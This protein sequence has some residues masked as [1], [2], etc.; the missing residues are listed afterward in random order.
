[1][2]KFNW[3]IIMVLVALIT[4]N[5][6]P[7]H[8]NAS[9]LEGEVFEIDG[10]N[11]VVEELTQEEFIVS[12]TEDGIDYTL[13][14]NQETNEFDIKVTDYTYKNDYF[15]IG[16]Q[17]DTYN[18]EVEELTLDGLVIAEAQNIKDLNDTIEVEEQVEEVIY[19]EDE[20]ETNLLEEGNT[21]ED[22]FDVEAQSLL[23]LGAGAIISKLLISLA[24]TVVVVVVGGITYNAARTSAA[25]NK[26]K[27]A[28][29]YYAILSTKDDVFIGNKIS[30][31]SKA[32][33][34][35]KLGGGVFA[36]SQTK[37]LNAVKSASPVNKSTSVQKHT[38]GGKSYSHYHPLDAKS[39]QMRAHC[40]FY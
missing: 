27:K 34:H 31:Q 38:G 6:F 10:Q 35:M 13:T 30:S 17:V 9:E 16:E 2:K 14:F 3:L 40:W 23:V 33:S 26:M 28:D 12:T 5:L 37:A 19:S 4:S 18:L 20:E 25:K 22:S 24:A 1:M 8:I 15:T 36:T 29:Y 39:K 11:V 32:A 7:V 21:T